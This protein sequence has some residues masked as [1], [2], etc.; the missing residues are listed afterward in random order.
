MDQ[1]RRTALASL[2]AGVVTGLAGCT[3][4]LGST[5]SGGEQPTYLPAK[6]RK[7]DPELLPY[8]T[9][10]DRVPTSTV[11][12]PLREAD[13]V[14]VPDA[15]AGR[16][17]LMT[18]VYTTCMTMCPRLT[19]ILSN[20]Q[21]HAL[22]NDYG[23]RVAFAEMTFDPARDDAGR[24]RYWGNT[25]NVDMDAGNW[26]F[27]RPAT[28][29]RAK[30]VVSDTYGVAFQR[31]SPDTMDAYM[32]AHAGIIL[33]ANKRGYVERTYKLRSA[34]SSAEPVTW[35]DVLEDLTT[36]RDREP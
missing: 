9:H 31:T 36:L 8:P 35:A 25:H 34:N 10:G 3:G 26:Y 19:A 18:F 12:A 27:L 28:R 6:E 33:L 14:T 15:F 17:L 22:D 24:F 32:F 20:V 7:V 2:G 30:E 16:D 4:V 11:G 5:A 21:S 23:D 29:E 1:T 13:A